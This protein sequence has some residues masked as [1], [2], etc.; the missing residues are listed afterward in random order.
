MLH[1]VSEKNVHKEENENEN[2]RVRYCV[3]L[4]F[5]EHNIYS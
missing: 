2:I 3:T 1:S 5:D 4:Q